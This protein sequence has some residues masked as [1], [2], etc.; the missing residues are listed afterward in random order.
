VQTVAHGVIGVTEFL[1][2]A[3]LCGERTADERLGL[4]GGGR[5]GVGWRA[6][7]PRCGRGKECPGE[8]KEEGQRPAHRY[9]F[10]LSQ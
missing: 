6:L 4:S 10:K 1:S 7:T 8:Q 3:G 9:H 5:G 2:G